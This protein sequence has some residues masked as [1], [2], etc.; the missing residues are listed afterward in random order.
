M[1][2]PAAVAPCSMDRSSGFSSHVTQLTHL[3]WSDI[4]FFFC[5]S[6]INLRP[7]TAF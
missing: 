1:Q 4:F 2:E 5:P 6:Q 7:V 3:S